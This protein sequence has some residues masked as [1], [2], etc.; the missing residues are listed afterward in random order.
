MVK[1]WFIWDG[2]AESMGGKWGWTAVFWAQ[3][4]PHTP[5]S[6]G[7]PYPPS[8][9]GRKWWEPE[10][11]WVQWTIWCLFADLNKN[12]GWQM[13]LD[14]NLPKFWIQGLDIKAYTWDGCVRQKQTNKQ[15]LKN[16]NILIIR[17]TQESA[18][19]HPE[20]KWWLNCQNPQCMAWAHSSGSLKE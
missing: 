3:P 18:D 11:C 16:L 20:L 6:Q 10:R 15:E 5:L 17:K 4:F 12:W 13:I 9:K 1:I 8:R 19:I 2:S 7:W 14:L